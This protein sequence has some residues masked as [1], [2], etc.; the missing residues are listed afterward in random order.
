MTLRARLALLYTAIVV[1]IL[2][3]FGVAVYL[4]VSISLTNEIEQSPRNSASR[5]PLVYVSDQGELSVNVTPDIEFAADTFIQVW[6]RDNQL[7]ANSA[8]VRN[9]TQPLDPASLN[10]S[11]PISN[12]VL[13]K[14]ETDEI[15]LRVLTVPLVLGDRPIGAI[16][17][18]TS[19][20]IVDATQK[21]LV[22]V[23]IIGTLISILIAGLASWISTRQ[24]LS[25]LE[26]VTETALQITRADDLSRRIPYTG[27][28]NDEIGQLIHAFNQTL[29]R[30]ENLFNTQRRFLADVGHELRTPLT[31]IK[32]NIDLMRRMKE[33]D[34]ESME[35]IESE[36]ERM[37]RLVGDLLL[38]SQAESGKLPLHLQL[39]ELDTLLIEV[40]G[41]MRVIAKDKVAL[42]LGEMD[43]VQVCADKD[44][45]K[46]VFVNLVQNAIHYTPRGGKVVVSLRKSDHQ[47]LVSVSDNGPGISPQDLPYIFER[48][49]RGEKARTRSKDGK[50]FG[51]G[52][53]IAYWIVKNHDGSIEVDSKLGEGTTFR[54]HL[55]MSISRCSEETSNTA[56]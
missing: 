23:L 47:A 35:S 17:V 49:Y 16:Q 32:G 42:V 1:G 53:S 18:G 55:P 52:L 33:L 43:Q 9:L 19:L 41:Q 15:Y 22:I 48:F 5:V 45:L 46:Q 14:T 2:L 25:P 24:A 40:L 12:D 13:L 3:L 26:D 11:K 30:L 50:G 31:V 21:S 10:A 7:R 38:L 44:K 4:S 54:V 36:V 39:I 28:P 20:A 8:N 51:L 37:T 27:P 6:D 29:G 34:E 56:G